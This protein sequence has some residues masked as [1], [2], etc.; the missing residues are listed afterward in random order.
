[1]AEAVLTAIGNF[2][3]QAGSAVYSATGSSF[4]ANAAYL[5]VV[6][7]GYAAVIA[8]PAL[9]A[10]ALTNLPSAEQQKIPFR[11]AVPPRQSGFGRVRVSGP[12]SL[13]EEYNGDSFDCVPFHDGKIDA[14]ETYY[15]HDDIVTIGSVSINDTAYTDGVSFSGGATAQYR[16]AIRFSATTGAATETAHPCL[17]DLPEWGSSHRGDGIASIGLRCYGVKREKFSAAYPYG[18]PQPSVVA[19]LQACF[20][21]NSGSDDPDDTSTWDWTENTARELLTYL[22]RDDAGGLGLDYARRIEPS[23]ASW[24]AG[25]DVCDES[26]SLKAG[27]TEARYRSG[28]I[29]LHNNAPSDV[30]GALLAACDGWLGEAGDGSLKFYAGKYTAP[31]VTFTDDHIRGYSWNRFRT[32]E[33]AANEFQGTY[34]EP[35]LDYSE[36]QTDPWVDADD[37]AARGQTRT[38]SV[39]LNWVQS[40]AQARRLLKR[41]AKKS[42]A[43]QGRIVT[44]LYGLQAFGERYVAIQNSEL[45]SMADIVVEILKMEI[46]FSRQEVEF[47][48]VQ[49]D[50]SIDNW[51]PASEE[52]TAPT[53]AT[54]VT[55]INQ[56]APTIDSVDV[57]TNSGLQMQVN[58]D[59]P[60]IYFATYLVRYRQQTGD[61]PATYNEWKYESFTE[62]DESGSTVP[63]VTS[64]IADGTYQVQAALVLVTGIPTDF[65]ASTEV[66]VSNAVTPE[67]PSG[68]AGGTL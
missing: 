52:G 14:V 66:V 3:V 5:T 57:L 22:I 11:Q 7:T 67:T 2:A 55:V 68:V 16:V 30:I 61:S 63:L 4:L 41:V 17:T 19:R 23:L 60:T 54:A 34:V 27:G 58:V 44:N 35:D 43:P 53:G 32:D 40:H 18:L 6:A 62:A 48:V 12:Y 46:H 45:P 20:D 9:L 24:Q 8:G 65:S 15:L 39:P 25:A 36:V 33:E 13:F 64:E 26:V 56:A 38:Q 42:V 51:T 1:M 28:G 21:P 29:F 10:R 47:T 50:S 31:T 59:T 37:I 49:V